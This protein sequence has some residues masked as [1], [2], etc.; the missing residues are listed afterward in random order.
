[1]IE[2]SGDDAG[3]TGWAKDMKGVRT[4]VMPTPHQKLPQIT[5]VVV[6]M[7]GNEQGVYCGGV[8]ALFEQLAGDTPPGIKQDALCADFE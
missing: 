7:V 1:L 2:Q 5:N 8:N 3:C 4:A 6:M